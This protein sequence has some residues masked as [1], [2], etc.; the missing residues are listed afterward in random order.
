MIAQT[1]LL[2]LRFDPAELDEP[3]KWDFPTL[4][5]LPWDQ[6][7]VNGWTEARDLASSSQ[8]NGACE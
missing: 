5:G 4:L 2:T 6:V 1:L 8:A 7:V 3:R